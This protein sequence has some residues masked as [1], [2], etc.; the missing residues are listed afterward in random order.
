MCGAHWAKNSK[1]KVPGNLPHVSS[2]WEE[3]VVHTKAL[4]VLLAENIRNTSC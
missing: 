3:T 2:E 4:S 1:A